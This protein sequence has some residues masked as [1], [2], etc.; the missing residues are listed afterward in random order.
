[1]EWS[2]ILE[3][4]RSKVPPQLIAHKDAHAHSTK[5]RLEHLA[6]VLGTDIQWR[7]TAYGRVYNA[8]VHA[9]IMHAVM[10]ELLTLARREPVVLNLIPNNLQELQRALPHMRNALWT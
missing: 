7:N 3:H 5:T 2:R 8:A 10:E 4:L 1:M 6:F 9:T